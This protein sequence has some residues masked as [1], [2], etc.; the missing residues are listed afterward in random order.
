MSIFNNYLIERHQH[1]INMGT[2]NIGPL[3]TFAWIIL[4]FGNFH[5]ISSTHCL[6][7]RQSVISAQVSGSIRQMGVEWST[8]VNPANPCTNWKCPVRSTSN[9]TMNIVYNGTVSVEK[10]FMRVSEHLLRLYE[11]EFVASHIFKSVGS[12]CQS[13]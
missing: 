4:Y 2:L 7:A 10:T 13:K 5:F 9:N 11:C 8:S 1:F 12:S 6:G 3:K